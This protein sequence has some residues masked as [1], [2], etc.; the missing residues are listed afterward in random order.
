MLSQQ[1][2]RAPRVAQDLIPKRVVGEEGF[3]PSR[4]KRPTDF[5]SVVYTVPPLAPVYEATKTSLSS[6]R[7]AQM[8]FS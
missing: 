7:C 8:L 1:L 4:P 6:L 3:E 5:K 2:G